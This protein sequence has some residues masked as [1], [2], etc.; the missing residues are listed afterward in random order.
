MTQGIFDRDT[1]G[2]VEGKQLLQQIESQVVALGEQCLERDLLLERKG[3]DVF[4]RPARLD[5]VVVFHSWCA[6]DIEDEG[7]LVVVCITLDRSPGVTWLAGWLVGRLLTVF[8]GKQG[9]S[10]QHLGQYAA[11][12]P[13]VNGF[14]VFLEGQ[15]DFRRTVP[16]SRHVFRHE[17]RVVVGRRRRSGQTKV[18]DF[19]IT[20]GVEQEVRRFQ[21]SVQDIS[22][23]H[24]FE[25][26]QRL[27]DEV[28][29]VVVGEVLSTDNTMHV[30]FHQ[31]LHNEPV[32]K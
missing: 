6:Q 25:R 28:L 30:G 31:F 11:D 22:R 8:P 15:H 32:S 12:T 4:S 27:V 9:L 14:C 23:V 2:R 19:Q 26:T 20:V 29:A 13:Y 3:S 5:S 10:A 1:L 17:A 18:A 7:Q 21:V 24:G 16:A